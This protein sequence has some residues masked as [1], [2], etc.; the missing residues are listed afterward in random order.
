MNNLFDLV[1]T[2]QPRT[3]TT[4]AWV[5]PY[6]PAFKNVT[7][8]STTLALQP[9]ANFG[10]VG[11]E[12]VLYTPS[13]NLYGAD[14][15][16]FTFRDRPVD[17]TQPL[18]ASNAPFEFRFNIAP[19]NDPPV[20]LH[21]EY[22]IP[23]EQAQSGTPLLKA[24][25]YYDVETPH[26]NLSVSLSPKLGYFDPLTNVTYQFFTGSGIVT[27]LNGSA[28]NN[29]DGA[30]DAL[31]FQYQPLGTYATTDSFTFTVFDGNLSATA[32]I[33]ITSPSKQSGFRKC[34]L[35]LGICRYSCVR[36]CSQKFVTRA[37]QQVVLRVCRGTQQLL[38]FLFFVCVL[39]RDVFLSFMSFLC[40]AFIRFMCRRGVTSCPNDPQ[41]RT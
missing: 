26:A 23:A 38:F 35:L 3:T 21:Q 14:L 4:P 39:S 32:T 20:A 5:L 31:V 6:A 28:I 18:L 11:T 7:V 40:T 41:L 33:T 9:W 34:W 24:L 27:L 22:K 13:E 15:V 36:V 19:V 16:R 8:T 17:G 2:T 29:T 10:V 30:P 12:L 37:C 1:I 25:R